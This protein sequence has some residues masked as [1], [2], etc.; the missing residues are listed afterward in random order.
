MVWCGIPNEIS[1][2]QVKWVNWQM[3]V[4]VMT[5]KS[6]QNFLRQS[7]ERV[8]NKKQTQKQQQNAFR[9]AMSAFWVKIFDNKINPK[10]LIFHFI[11]IFSK[12]ALTAYVQLERAVEK[13]VML[14]S[15][16]LE[17]SFQLNDLPCINHNLERSFQHNSFQPSDFSNCSF[18]LHLCR[19]YI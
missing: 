10:I 4:V 15:F 5:L 8:F 16:K 11:L 13:I 18:Q 12:D 1:W 17:R 14:E 2:Y 6:F 9:N 7:L 19:I 3:S